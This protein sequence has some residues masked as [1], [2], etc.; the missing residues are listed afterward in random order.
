M[1]KY[2]VTGGAGFI[3]SALVRGLLAT[4]D[5]SVE[6]IDNLSTGREDNLTEVESHVGFHRTDIR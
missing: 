5:G 1:K 4:G 6:V 2:I 3:G